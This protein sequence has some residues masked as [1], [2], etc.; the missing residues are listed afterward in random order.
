MQMPQ[1]SLNC[2]PQMTSS[3]ASLAV[4]PGTAMPLIV[5]CLSE[6]VP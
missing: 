4:R 1:K 3:W 5:F 6:A 2:L